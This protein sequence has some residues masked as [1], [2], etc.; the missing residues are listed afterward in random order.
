MKRILL[1]ASLFFVLP[2]I[3]SAQGTFPFDDLKPIL[4]Q[5]PELAKYLFS[6]LEFDE[7]G[8]ASR[9]GSNVNEKLGGQRVG[10]YLIQAKPKGSAGPKVFEVTIYTEQT[11]LDERGKTT[12]LEKASSV[13]EKFEHLEVRVIDE[14]TKPEHHKSSSSSRRTRVGTLSCGALAAAAQELRPQDTKA[15]DE[16]AIRENVKQMETGWNTKSGALF[17]RPFAEDAD[18]VVING[19]HIRGRALI[20]KGHQRI[21]DTIYKQTGLSLTVEQIRF[22]RPD[23]ALVHVLGHSKTPQA[24]GFR[25]SDVI[26]TLVMT[27]DNQG[28]K[29]AAFQNTQVE[30]PQRK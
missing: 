15:S 24:D 23:V 2:Q 9:I 18:Y 25:E 4:N 7:G 5:K 17:A 13:T 21:F 10:P 28:W 6:T 1:L 11:F 27:K 30:N 16:A 14:K 29:I 19:T 8:I 22:L 12:T 3:A 20:D 26:I